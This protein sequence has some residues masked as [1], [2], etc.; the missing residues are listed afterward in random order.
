MDARIERQRQ[1]TR[2]QLIRHLGAKNTS[3]A[4]RAMKR[5]RAQLSEIARANGSPTGDPRADQHVVDR[6]GVGIVCLAKEPGRLA[7]IW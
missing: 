4:V 5:L 1:V 2:D 6:H 7:E 3:A